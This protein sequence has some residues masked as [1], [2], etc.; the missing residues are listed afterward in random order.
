MPAQPNVYARL[1]IAGALS[2]WCGAWLVF[3]LHQYALLR[4]CSF[5]SG[6]WLPCEPRE[7]VGPLVLALLPI[8]TIACA[9]LTRGIARRRRVRGAGDPFARS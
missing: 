1:F 7:W 5:L 4:R 9:A 2:L 6:P 3:A 8:A